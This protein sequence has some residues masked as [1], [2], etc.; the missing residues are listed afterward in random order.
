MATNRAWICFGKDP[1]AAVWEEVVFVSALSATTITAGLL[2]VTYG[3]TGANLSATGG[4]THFLRQASA[5]AAI[6]VGAIA[7]SDLPTAID[8]AKIADGTVSNTEF[9]YLNGVTSLLQTQL[10]AKQPKLVTHAT[11]APGVNDDTTQGYVAF[12]S[13]WWEQDARVLWICVDHTTGA[14]DWAGVAFPL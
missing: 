2:G 1:A 11:A 5:G 14:A 4:A 10:D 8:S 12:V 3:G 13:L 9:Q 7:A 6:T